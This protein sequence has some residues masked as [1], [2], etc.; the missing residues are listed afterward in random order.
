MFYNSKLPQKKKLKIMYKYIG[1]VECVDFAQLP[2]F[3]KDTTCSYSSL[4]SEINLGHL[5]DQRHILGIYDLEE[6]QLA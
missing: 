1:S 6:I 5:A 4:F 3:I 2:D